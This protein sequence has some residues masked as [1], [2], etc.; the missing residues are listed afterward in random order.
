LYSS[1]DIIRQIKSRRKVDEA[2]GTQGRG[3]ENVQDLVGKPIGNNQ[4]E[5]RGVDGRMG[6]K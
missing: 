6:S 5:D 4:L 2:C 1:P 3:D